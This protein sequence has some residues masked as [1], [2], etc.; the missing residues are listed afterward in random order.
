MSQ[1]NSSGILI[2][3]IS[4]GI[5]ILLVNTILLISHTRNMTRDMTDM[6]DMRKNEDIVRDN[7]EQ[8][9]G[10]F[11][12]GGI[13]NGISEDSNPFQTKMAC[14]CSGYGVKR[15]ENMPFNDDS[16]LYNSPLQKAQLRMRD[17]SFEG[18]E[19]FGS[20]EGFNEVEGSLPDGAECGVNRQMCSKLCKSRTS[21]ASG[22]TAGTNADA[23]LL[24]NYQCGPQ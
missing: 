21:H 9:E 19:G 8:S 12:N 16:N 5:G 7:W 13:Y 11:D 10:M 3:L 6:R 2:T 17:N 24:R 1:D 18:L 22:L 4:I 15:K 20:F 23:P 14:S